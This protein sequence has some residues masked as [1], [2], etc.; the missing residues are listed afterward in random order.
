[1][2]DYWRRA[3]ERRNSKPAR[4][5]GAVGSGAVRIR[6]LG[7]FEVS[8]ARLRVLRAALDEATDVPGRL[9]ALYPRKRG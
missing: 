7:R 4:F 6:L 5:S 8:L 3:A 9:V 2:A 1:M